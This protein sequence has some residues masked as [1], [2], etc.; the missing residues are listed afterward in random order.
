MTMGPYVRDEA[1]CGG[2]LAR[3][4]ETLH[5]TSTHEIQTDAKKELTVAL[6]AEHHSVKSSVKNGK[7]S[8][9]SSSLPARGRGKEETR[10]RLPYGLR[11]MCTP[12]IL[13]TAP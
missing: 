3:P 6:G 9:S 10:Y 5:Q 7:T 12:A 4:G 8:S 11:L 1:N 2:N 13:T